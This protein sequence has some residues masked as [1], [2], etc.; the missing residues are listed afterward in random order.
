MH[1]RGDHAAKRQLHQVA[2]YQFRRGYSLPFAVS[3][4]RGVERQTGFESSK[5]GLSAAFLEVSKSRVE[6]EQS[7]YDSSF[8]ILMQDGL[9]HNGRFKQPWYRRPEFSQCIAQWMSRRVR[10]CIGTVFFKT[11][12]RFFACEAS[13]GAILSRLHDL[14]V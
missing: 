7:C 2:A 1:I 12:A 5:S 11:G 3:L 9:K 14:P 13:W 4:D 10:H 6:K 8:V